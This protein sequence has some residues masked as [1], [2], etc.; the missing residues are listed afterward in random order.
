MRATPNRLRWLFVCG[1][2]TCLV[3]GAVGVIVPGLPTTVF[4][5]SGSYLLTRGSPAL[6]ERL[7]KSALFSPYLKYLDP[8]VG[9][10]RAAKVAAIVSMWTSISLSAAL[11]R[12]GGAGA[13]VLLGV[14]V[15]GIAGTWMIVVFRNGVP[16]RCGLDHA[17]L[18]SQ[19]FFGPLARRPRYPLLPM[20][21]E[22]NRCVLSRP[23]PA[24]ER[25]VTQE[26]LRC[27]PC[28]PP[29]RQPQ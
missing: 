1:G 27:G 18:A 7:R 13:T 4:V 17:T 28:S 22:S 20:C 19:A 9:M 29:T 10:P 21:D 26:A 6:N 11:L 25:R 5:L 3:L 12:I 23:E 8:A 2:V 14:F 24:G 16:Q 15:A